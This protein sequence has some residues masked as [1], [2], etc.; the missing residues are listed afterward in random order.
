[1][2]RMLKPPTAKTFHT[3]RGLAWISLA[4]REKGASRRLVKRFPSAANLSTY[5]NTNFMEGM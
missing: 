5:P 1:L 4:Q 3:P 2:H